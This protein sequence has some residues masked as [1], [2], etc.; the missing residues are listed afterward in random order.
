MAEERNRFASLWEKVTST[1]EYL[2]LGAIIASSLTLIAG[3]IALNTAM[4]YE[5]KTAEEGDGGL[6]ESGERPANGP[7]IDQTLVV[8]GILTAAAATTLI[9]QTA[10]ILAS[11]CCVYVYEPSL[12]TLVY[13]KL[14]DFLASFVLVV[15][16]T[17][18]T[19]LEGVV[20]YHWSNINQDSRDDSLFRAVA[21]S[22]TFA[23]LLC[24]I[25]LALCIVTFYTFYLLH[26]SSSRNRQ[27][28]VSSIA[29]V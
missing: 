14:T 6:V 13:L 3:A 9:L 24:L 22:T 29:A 21:G 17:G 2:R 1:G 12:S 8:T 7:L 18:S 15:A 16:A 19:T 4:K 11:K 10:L 23:S 20:A 27:K 25:L 26:K 5:P 28:T